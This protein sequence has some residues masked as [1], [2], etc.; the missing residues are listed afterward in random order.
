MGAATTAAP[1]SKSLPEGIYA[2]ALVRLDLRRSRG[3][4]EPQGVYPSALFGVGDR[5]RRRHEID[6]EQ[7]ETKHRL[8]PF[9]DRPDHMSVIAHG[10]APV[11]RSV[12][13]K[14]DTFARRTPNQ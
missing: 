1:F 13:P 9:R 7:N 5:G 3:R 12:G 4:V 6:Q 10:G 14:G 11:G 8:L 2:P